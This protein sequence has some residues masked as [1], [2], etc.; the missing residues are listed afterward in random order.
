MKK[1]IIFGTSFVL[2]LAGIFAKKIYAQTSEDSGLGPLEARLLEIGRRRD[3][4]FVDELLGRCGHP[5]SYLRDDLD[6]S[7][8]LAYF[9]DRNGTRDWVAYVDLVHGFVTE[10]G[11]N[12]A[13][14]NDHSSFEPWPFEEGDL[15]GDQLK[16]GQQ[17]EAPDR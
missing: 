5:D 1:R 4:V 17:D 9:Y 8:M 6:G 3:P 14:V 16:S 11:F 7:L 10:V 2:L 12:D 13:T 15:P